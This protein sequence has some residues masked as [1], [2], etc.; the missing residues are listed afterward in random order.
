MKFK[1]ENW[2][3]AAAAVAL[4]AQHQAALEMAV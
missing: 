2:E 4:C 1:F 3:E